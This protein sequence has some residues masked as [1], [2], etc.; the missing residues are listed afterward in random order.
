MELK[1]IKKG[2]FSFVYISREDCSVCHVLLPKLKK[3]SEK[4][5]DADF[6]EIDLEVIPQAAGEFSVFSIPA[7][8]VYS[9]GKELY[10]GA[11]FFNMGEL[12]EKL[13]R[14]YSA[15]FDL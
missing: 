13:D 15:I 7:L 12:E 8:I 11:R 5:L 14:Y 4:Y 2:K 3:L 10:R 1:E 9:E 6:V